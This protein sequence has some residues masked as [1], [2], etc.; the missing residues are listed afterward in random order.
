MSEVT[1]SYSKTDHGNPALSAILIGNGYRL[2]VFLST[3]P[4]ASHAA[5]RRGWGPRAHFYADLEIMWQDNGNPKDFVLS[6]DDFVVH[7]ERGYATHALALGAV[8]WLK[9]CVEI[10]GVEGLRRH[11]AIHQGQQA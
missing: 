2:D 4:T 1:W 7:I 3:G 10:A 9:S 8:E 5:G 11:N 6:R